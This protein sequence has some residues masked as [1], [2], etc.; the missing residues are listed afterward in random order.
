MTSSDVVAHTL[1]R[2]NLET[3]VADYPALANYFDKPLE[4][5]AFIDFLGLSKLIGAI[6][7]DGVAQIIDA[8]SE[9][10]FAKRL[11]RDLM[12]WSG[13]LTGS[14]NGD[15]IRFILALPLVRTLPSAQ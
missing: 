6:P 8:L 9:E 12:T 7:R 1:N 11:D 4:Q 14:G 2:A 10:S 3:I 5:F 15:E 13:S